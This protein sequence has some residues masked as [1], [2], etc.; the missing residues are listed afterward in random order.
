M[1]TRLIG[2]LIVVAAFLVAAAGSTT[3]AADPSPA[4]VTGGERPA[5]SDEIG[6]DEGFRL[7]SVETS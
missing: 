7:V 3:L 1:K 4:L 6:G 5:P 2:L